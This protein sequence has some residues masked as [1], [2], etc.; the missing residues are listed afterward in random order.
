MEDSFWINLLTT[1]KEKCN[2]YPKLNQLI[3]TDNKERKQ[4]KFSLKELSNII[5]KDI[6]KFI[7]EPYLNKW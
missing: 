3:E 2:E 6:I 7:I 1:N 5:N 4:V